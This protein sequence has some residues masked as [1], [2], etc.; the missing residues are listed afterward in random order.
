MRAEE[1]L[2]LVADRNSLEQ[3]LKEVWGSGS[4]T[5]AE[6]ACQHRSLALEAVGICNCSHYVGAINGGRRMHLM[7]GARASGMLYVD[8]E[9]RQLRTLLATELSAK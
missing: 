1:I 4:A 3:T 2:S 9:T 7:L 6:S 8:T 5:V